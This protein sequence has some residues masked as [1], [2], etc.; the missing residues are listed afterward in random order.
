MI[1]PY[2]ECDEYKADI[3]FK[4][5][6]DGG[7][8][9]YLHLEVKKWNKTV[10]ETLREHLR[11]LLDEMYEAGFDSL[12][13]YLKKGHP[14]KFHNMVRPLDYE[15]DFGPNSDYTLGGWLTEEY[16]NGGI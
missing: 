8:Y 10:L 11:F 9:A 4:T 1:F 5:S 14:T 2:Y 3:E 13:F 7:R 16:E 6:G 12:S 15:T